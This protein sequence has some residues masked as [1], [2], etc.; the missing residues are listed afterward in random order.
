MTLGIVVIVWGLLVILAF[1]RPRLGIALIWPLVWLYPNTLL[2]D[3][4]PLNVRF[5]DLFVVFTFLAVLISPECRGRMGPLFWLAV[6]WW[7]SEA[8]G[9]ATGVVVAGSFA[10]T[11]ALKQIGKALYVPLTVYML[12]GAIQTFP[13][14][15]RQVLAIGIAAAAAGTLAVVMV[16]RPYEFGAFLIP[17]VNLE[18][19]LT[20]A[21][22]R[23]GIENVLETRAQGAVGITTLSVL[24][25]HATL[26]CIG[27]MLWHPRPLTRALYGVL[28]AASAITLLHTATRGAIGGLVAGIAWALL[29]TRRRGLLATASAVAAVALVLQG[30]VLKRIL[31]RVT[32]STGY[33]STFTEGLR[34]R[35][36]IW[37]RFIDNFSPIYLFV[38][39]GMIGAFVEQKATAHNTY[40][41]ALVYGGIVGVIILVLLVRAAIVRA[42]RA[43][44]TTADWASQALGTYVGMLVAA[45]LVSG[46]VMENFQQVTAV[47]LLFAALVFID[48][49][50]GQLAGAPTPGLSVPALLPDQPVILPSPYVPTR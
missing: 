28:A 3:S 36:E 8:V 38:G 24:S 45:L 44:A 13:Q 19:G 48:L 42:R 11:A 50:Q 18:T 32:E 40:L 7:L 17:S 4:L 14:L 34:V 39:S 43:L 21:E 33:Q 2:Y 15:Q 46:F 49:R 1:L 47:Q 26:L 9:T 6:F 27:F 35:F 10:W 5:D 30:N 31:L 20:A 12:Y 37:Q 25:Q 16:Y 29:F 22:I 23:E 41:G